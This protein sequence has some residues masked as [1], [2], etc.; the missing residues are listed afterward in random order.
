MKPVKLKRSYLDKCKTVS[1]VE[2]LKN[3][4]YVLK[5]LQECLYP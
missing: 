3:K 4:E 2:K 5:I 1:E